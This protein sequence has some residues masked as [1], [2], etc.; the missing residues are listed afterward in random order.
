MKTFWK[1]RQFWRTIILMMGVSLL[2]VIL[3]LL[4]L[5]IFTRQGQSF[6]VPDFTGLSINQLG[7]LQ[8]E[9]G[10]EFEIIDS[11]FDRSQQPGTVLRHDPAPNATVKR[12]RKFYVTLV[13][14]TPDMVVMP[15]LIDL[16]L[17]QATSLL[18]SRGLFVGTITY[19]SGYFQNAVFDQIYRGQHIPPGE[20][21][22][23]GTYINLIVS[24]TG[25]SSQEETDE[26]NEDI[27][28]EEED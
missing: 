20:N 14:S 7:T 28:F 1:T 6:I 27:W 9:Y 22:R 16:S 12:G 2:I 8:K 13:S 5:R 17:R 4:S 18:E 21:V 10:F 24:G 25:R 3:T 11:V 23:K 19:Q 15:N 26:E